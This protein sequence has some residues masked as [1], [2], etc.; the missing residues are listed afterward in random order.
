VRVRGSLARQGAAGTNVF[1]FSGRIGGRRLRPGAYR[2]VAVARDSSGAA[3][4]PARARFRIA[5]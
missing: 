1:R 5:R 3:S 4:K 2:L